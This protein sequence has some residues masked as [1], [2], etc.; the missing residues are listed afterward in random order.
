MDGVVETG[1]KGHGWPFQSRHNRMLCRDGPVGA[2]PTMACPKGASMGG[3]SLGSLSLGKPRQVLA[4]PQRGPFEVRH[5]RRA[6]QCASLSA[7]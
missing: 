4:R 1:R 6:K 2:A 5:L 7:C 3:A